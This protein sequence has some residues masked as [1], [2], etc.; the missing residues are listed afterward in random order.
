MIVDFFIRT[1]RN[2]KNFAV[3]IKMIILHCNIK[4]LTD[5]SD[6]LVRKRKKKWNTAKKL[7]NFTKFLFL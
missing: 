6:L 1:I 2:D 5:Q 7:K 3:Q 4:K